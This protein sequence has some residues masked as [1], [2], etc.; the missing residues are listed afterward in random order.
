[1]TRRL[2]IVPAAALA[3][4]FALVL[5]PHTG[6]AASRTQT[7]RFFDK[8]VSSKLTRADGTVIT[9]APYPDPAPGDTLDVDSLDYAGNHSHHAKHWMGSAHLRCV[10]GNGAPTCESETAIGGSLLIFT[11]TPGRVTDGTG[12]YQGATGLV[13]SATEVPH[14]N[15]ATDVLAK[16]H[17]R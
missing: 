11:G 9:H 2:T 4:A 17:R 15:N 1:M 5:W 10:F 8:P 13:I 3:A 6:N 14:T 7:L 12:V 16:I